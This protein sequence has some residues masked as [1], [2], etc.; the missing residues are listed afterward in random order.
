MLKAF[1][2]ILITTTL[3]AQ[4]YVDSTLTPY[5]N[6]YITDMV[7]NGIFPK[8]YI[9]LDSIITVPRTQVICSDSNTNGCSVGVCQKDNTKRYKIFVQQYSEEDSVSKTQY[10][11]YLIYHELGHAIFGLKH[12]NSG[13]D[14]MNA[15]SDDSE[16]CTDWKP[17]HDNYI[18]RL[19]N[20]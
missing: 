14:I 19:K 16:Y 2:L 12:Y 1:L 4:P 8:N 13:I 9:L 6:T 3:K 20:Y 7:A 17:S 10:Y 11:R 15:Y 5:V 18:K